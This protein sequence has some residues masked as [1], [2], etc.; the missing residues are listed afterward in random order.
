MY[1]SICLYLLDSKENFHPENVFVSVALFERLRYCL[2]WTLPQAISGLYDMIAS[3]ERMDDF[4]KMPQ[5]SIVEKAVN[6]SKQKG[7]FVK[8]LCSRGLFDSKQSE[9]H[10]QLED[11]SFDICSGQVLTIVGLVGSGKVSIF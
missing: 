9:K 7:I 11:I 4:L 8:N 1:F 2:T 6:N 10:F 5:K 3:C